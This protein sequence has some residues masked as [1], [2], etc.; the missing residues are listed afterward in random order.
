MKKLT[1]FMLTAALL[2]VTVLCVGTLSVSA[3][4]GDACTSTAGCDGTYENG[5]CPYCSGY[6]EPAQ[7]GDG[8]Y[9]IDNAGKLFWF[10]VKVNTSNAAANARLTADIE[11]TSSVLGTRYWTPIGVRGEGFSG[12]FDGQGYTISHITCDMTIVSG[13]VYASLFYTVSANGVVKNVGI[14]DSTFKSEVIVGSIVV[15]NDGT[16][17]NCFSNANVNAIYHSGYTN[18]FG[19]IVGLNSGTVENCHFS[20]V[21]VAERGHVGGIA[22]GNEG[23]LRNCYY[24]NSLHIGYAVGYHGSD[25]VTEKI[26]GKTHTEF[27]NGVVCELVGYHARQAA[28]CTQ[29]TWC[30]ICGIKEDFNLSNHTDKTHVNGFWL[31]CGEYQPATQKGV[32]A[33]GMPLYEIANA[34]EL[35]WFAALVNKN[36]A[37]ENYPLTTRHLNAKLVSDITV[38]EGQIGADGSYTPAGDETPRQWSPIV[39]FCGQFDG[40]GKTIS[41]LYNANGGS[42][43]GF[44]TALGEFIY[45]SQHNEDRP[46]TGCVKNLGITNSYFMGVSHV[47]ALVGSQFLGTSIENCWSDALVEGST[48]LVGGLVGQA[49]GGTLKNSIFFGVIKNDAY[50]SSPNIVGSAFPVYLV[51]NSY[52]PYG[53]HDW[54]GATDQPSYQDWYKSREAFASGE[55]TVLLNEAIGYHYFGQ[56]LG[57]DAGPVIGG[58]AVY[59]SVQLNC[60]E[61]GY[62]NTPVGNGAHVPSGEWSADGTQHW[63]AC[64][65]AGCDEKLDVTAHVHDNACDT[66]C[67]VCN[68]ARTTAHADANEDDA[69]D[70]CHVQLQGEG[71]SVGAGIGIG[72]GATAV[73][74][75][76]GFAVFWFA[77]KKCKWSDLV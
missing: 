12:T 66:A 34:G 20:G 22:G 5:F 69:C 55:V 65:V 68:E 75:L 31:C 63:H 4:D 9:E 25:M 7:D 54:Q 46:S 23:T 70:V 16:V 37:V 21:I 40:N 44:F 38:N 45:S 19:G 53:E 61:Y 30:K 52:S 77:I 11:V 73:L 76:G 42:N 49:R 26:E 59:A 50:P 18:Y 58:P 60:T 43:V 10:A 28:T 47:A 71:L 67:N 6:E 41:G 39:C 33:N 48:A 3:A 35:Y 64:T 74:L 62:A 36:E 17:Q 72:A 32:G 15:F 57:K 8:Y 51:I 56:L 13:D 14:L 1:V 27:E 2:L 29:E 24:D